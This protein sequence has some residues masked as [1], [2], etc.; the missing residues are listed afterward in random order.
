MN[1]IDL[2]SKDEFKMLCYPG[3]LKQRSALEHSLLHSTMDIEINVWINM[4]LYE[5][6]KYDICCKHNL[7]FK[8]I[9]NHFRNS[10]EALLMVCKHEIQRMDLPLS[11]RRYLIGKRYHLEKIL[12][13]HTAATRT[14]VAKNTIRKSEPKYLDNCRRITEKLSEEY[15]IGVNTV[16]KYSSYAKAIDIIYD[17]TP[18]LALKTLHE[19][20]R[21]STENILTISKMSR[22]D[23]LQI[24]EHVLSGAA[25]FETFAGS[26][27][28]FKNNDMPNAQQ[29]IQGSIKDM[30]QY[31]P[32][33]EIAS[34]SLT[35]PSWISSMKRVCKVTDIKKVSDDAK[36]KLSKELE[37]LCNQIF[38]TFDFIKEK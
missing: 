24:S 22:N 25:E 10:E 6:E 7:P 30:P 5:H 18:D 38:E 11:M 17:Y 26:R 9:K 4:V 14:A 15:D 31:D 2:R 19:K 12:G 8:I 36:N 1:K 37:N 23:I 35:I 34:L 29:S 33:A 3:T 27:K 13:E 28:L 32:D 21:I 16:A 20:I